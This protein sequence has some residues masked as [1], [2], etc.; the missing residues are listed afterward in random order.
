VNA[1]AIIVIVV[2]VLIVVL[3]L[4]GLAASSRRAAAREGSLRRQIAEANE[5]LALARA[6]DQ[7]WDRDLLDAAAR[8]ALSERHPGQAVEELLLVEVTDNPGTDEDMAVFRARCGTVE[9]TITLGRREGAWV[10][11]D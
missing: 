1:F 11:R 10:A 6:D 2:A 9:Q 4:G 5:A 3:A 8:A 7:G